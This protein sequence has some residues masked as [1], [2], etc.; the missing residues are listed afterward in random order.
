MLRFALLA[1]VLFATP[2]AAQFDGH[3]EYFTP[4]YSV[5]DWS[6]SCPHSSRALV[7]IWGAGGSGGGSAWSQFGGAGGSGAYGE[8]LISRPAGGLSDVYVGIGGHPVS[9]GSGNSGNATY[10]G[11]GPAECVAHSGGGGQSPAD[12]QT[13]GDGGTPGTIG[14]SS[15]VLYI[16]GGQ[17]QA[18]TPT[19]N[20]VNYDM[21]QGANAPGGGRGGNNWQSGQFPGG[22]GAP[23]NIL[24]PSGAGAAGGIYVICGPD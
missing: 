9:V 10:F 17:G 11:N 16:P 20:G 18:S 12:V 1:L 19:L 5:F 21:P 15:A 4:G 23:G 8:C 24:F 14:G 7:K 2:A 22:A 3:A 6:Q 13:G